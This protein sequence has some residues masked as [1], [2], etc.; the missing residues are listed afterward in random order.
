M[1]IIAALDDRNLLGASIRAAE[2]WKPWR[3]LLAATFGPISA[4]SGLHGADCAAWRGRRVFVASDRAPRR[5]VIRH[6]VD[7]RVPGRLEGLAQVPIARR[8]RHRPVGRG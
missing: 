5:Q 4:L 8:A 1:N 7:C 3:A 6:G 2:S